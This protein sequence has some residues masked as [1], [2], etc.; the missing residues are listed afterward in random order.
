MSWCG[1]S[2]LGI[3]GMSTFQGVVLSRVGCKFGFGGAGYLDV[4]GSFG[5]SGV[6]SLRSLMSSKSDN[7]VK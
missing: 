4:G 3:C 7:K 2:S 6:P 5:V 1:V